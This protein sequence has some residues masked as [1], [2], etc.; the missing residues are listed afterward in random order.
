LLEND[1]TGKEKTR[2]INIKTRYLWMVCILTIVMGAVACEEEAVEPEPEPE[3]GPYADLTQPDHV[4]QNMLQCY[5]DRNPE[6]Y[7]ELLYDPDYMFCFQEKDVEP[8]GEECLTLLFDY[9]I[10]RRIFLAAK[11]TPEGSDPALDALDLYIGEGNWVEVETIGGEPCEGCMVTERYY[12]ISVTIGQTIYTFSD[13]IAFGIKPVDDNGVTRY[14][15]LRAI[16][17]EH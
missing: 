8:G 2:V 15:I 12:T 14:K 7:L 17:L 16:D 9:D 3:P 11:G 13:D 1:R 10:T 5:T 6:R 4:I